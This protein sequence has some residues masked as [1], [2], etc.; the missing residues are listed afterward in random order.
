MLA[1]ETSIRSKKQDR[2]VKRATLPLHDSNDEIDA[3]FQSDL[4]KKIDRRTGDIHAALPVTAKILGPFFRSRADDS[5]KIQAS[6]VGGNERFRKQNQP[7][8]L[9]GG[10]T[11]EAAN[12]LQRALAFERHGGCLHHRNFELLRVCRHGVL[13]RLAGL[14]LD[15]PRFERPVYTWQSSANTMSLLQTMARAAR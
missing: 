10:V 9:A 5:T 13:T 1:Q 11:G 15:Q 2:A 8:A 14:G 7:S 12:F 4:A 3:I 6:R